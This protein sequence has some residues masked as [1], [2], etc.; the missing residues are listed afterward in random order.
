MRLLPFS[1]VEHIAAIVKR[2]VDIVLG[3]DVGGV[4][5]EER[6]IANKRG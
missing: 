6:I 4:L 3:V 5:Q 2:T 1:R